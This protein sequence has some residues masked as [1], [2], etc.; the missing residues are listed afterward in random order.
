M[1]TIQITVTNADDQIKQLYESAFP[2]EEQIPWD[3]LVR[4]IG[5]M[6]LDFTAYY[7]GSDF[8]GFTIV[9]PRPSYSWFWYFAVREEL[10]GK[11]YGQQILTLVVGK[12]RG[13]SLVM[14]I[15]STR[16]ESADNREIRRRRQA[17]YLRNG[18]QETNLF[19]GWSGIEYTILMLGPGTFTMQ[20]WDGVVAELRQY[21]TWETKNQLT[22][23]L[24]PAKQFAKEY[25]KKAKLPL[26]ENDLAKAYDAG[27]KFGKSSFWHKVGDQDPKPSH[28]NE[29][30][31]VMVKLPDDSYD[32]DVMK[33]S[34]YSDYIASK[35]RPGEPL[36][37]AYLKGMLSGRYTFPKPKIQRATKDQAPEI[38]NLI[39]MAMT[40]ECC[41]Y[42]CGEGYGLDDFRKMMTFLVEADVSQYSY[43]NTL[44]AV[45]SGKVVGIAV[46]YDGG[47]LKRLRRAF[48]AAAKEYLGKDHTGIDDET[49]AGE[50]Y[51][52]SLAVI[53]EYRRLG[54]A[55][56]LVMTA[57]KRAERMRL[58][59]GLLVD[60]NNPE[61]EAFYTHVGFQYEGDSQWGGHPMKHL[62]L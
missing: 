54:I 27:V 24:R 15:E 18:F 60:K 19:R 21:W 12:Y 9:Y 10:R 32:M 1:T 2:V 6:G 51:L 40:D 35:D 7:E 57:K 8:I 5:E 58:R 56:K 37:W 16:Q 3:D 28:M 44:V 17:F 50:L 46:S 36:F 43:K 11:G 31:V 20:D 29:Q 53:P 42:F 22:H 49:Q 55:R 26:T 13:Q 38:A 4:L 25:M 34:D 45:A 48:I 30:I 61:G 52:D 23:R 33:S 47:R 62:V 14:D 59:L 39:M 41:Q